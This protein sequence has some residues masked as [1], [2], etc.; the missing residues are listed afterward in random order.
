MKIPAPLRRH[1]LRRRAYLQLFALLVELL[2]RLAATVRLRRLDLDLCYGDNDPAR[3]GMLKGLAEALGGLARSRS[4]AIRLHFSPRFG[5][6]TLAAEA[7]LE[8]G[9]RPISLVHA[10]LR[11]LIS[12]FGKKQLRRLLVQILR[13]VWNGLH[14]P[15]E[16]VDEPERNF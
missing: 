1:L 10:L 15:A 16:P 7:E 2:R 11:T 6:R 14:T 3:C 8:I 4:R 9:L 5:E 13:Q 12:A